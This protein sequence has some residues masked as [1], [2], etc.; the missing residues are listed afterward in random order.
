MIPKFLFVL[1]R[2]IDMWFD[3]VRF[4][5]IMTPKNFDDRTCLIGFESILILGAISIFFC[6]LWKIMK[7]VLLT[8]S[9]SLLIFSQVET[10]ISSLFIFSIKISRF[11]CEANRLVSSANKTN[12]NKVVL[13]HYLELSQRS[14]VKYSLA[15]WGVEVTNDVFIHIVYCTV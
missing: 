11:I 7:L 4:S 10:L 2:T 13:Q 15:M 6:L 14:L 3:H 12:F 9:E 8:F 1:L 5:F